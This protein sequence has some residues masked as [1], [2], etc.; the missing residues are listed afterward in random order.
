MSDTE[1]LLTDERKAHFVTQQKLKDA[2]KT[3]KRLEEHIED[4]ESHLWSENHDLHEGDIE[5]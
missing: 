5:Y 3:I 2:R 4:L 1:Q